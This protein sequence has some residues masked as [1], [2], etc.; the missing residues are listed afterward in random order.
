MISNSKCSNFKQLVVKLESR[1]QSI[2]YGLKAQL[3]RVF[4]PD[5]CYLF[6][7]AVPAYDLAN[8]FHSNSFI[9]HLA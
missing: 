3:N 4:R 7:V 5:I 8:L 9:V 6:N 2:E 1:F